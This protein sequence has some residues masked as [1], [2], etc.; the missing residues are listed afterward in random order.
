MIIK[1]KKQANYKAP[2]KVVCPVCGESRT[3]KTKNL[4]QFC[5]PCALRHTAWKR[6]GKRKKS[7]NTELLAI[8][9]KYCPR[10]KKAVDVELFGKCASTPHGLYFYCKPCAREK[11]KKHHNEHKGK[12]NN[13]CR[14]Y[15]QENKEKVSERHKR[16]LHMKIERERAYGRKKR[17]HIRSLLE[18]FTVD[19]D[20]FCRSF[21]GNM[22]AVC[23]RNQSE[24]TQKMPIDHWLP[25]KPRD[26]SSGYPLSMGNAVLLC[27]PCNSRKH[28]KDARIVFGDEVA[29]EIEEKMVAQLQ[30]W[31]NADA[32]SIRPC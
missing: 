10:C 23:G 22:C 14:D 20:R 28:N 4:V 26:G 6:R 2:H 1:I 8:G 11:S 21:W 27:K 18:D 29:M 24:F 25:A 5:R 16:N 19:M 12:H 7:K 3:A 13:A 31:E 9:K 32:R 17:A 15:Y 30:E